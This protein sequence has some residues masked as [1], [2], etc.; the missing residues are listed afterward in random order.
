MC[1]RRALTSF[2][3]GVRFC[4]ALQPCSASCATEHLLQGPDQRWPASCSQ[5]DSSRHPTTGREWVVLLLAHN[6]CSDL[7]D[8]RLHMAAP[9]F[10]I[11]LCMER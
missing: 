10:D 4:Q 5:G 6:E 3:A 2:K 8:L 1:K 11:T 7:Y 9:A